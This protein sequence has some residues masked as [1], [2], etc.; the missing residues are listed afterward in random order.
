M[1]KQCLFLIILSTVLFQTMLAQ[2]ATGSTVKDPY[3]SLLGQ[4]QVKCFPSQKFLVYTDNQHLILEIVG[5]GRGELEK[6]S[7]NKF[8]LKGLKPAAYVEFKK[9]LND[10]AISLTWIQNSPIQNWTKDANDNNQVKTGIAA[11]V[12][13]YSIKSSAYQKMIMENRNNHLICTLI[14]PNREPFEIKPNGP[15]SFVFGSDGY[16]CEYAFAAD[17]NG[18]FNKLT[19][20]QSGPLLCPRIAMIAENPSAKHSFYKRPGFTRGDTL[21]GMLSPLRSCYDVL[22]YKL[23]VTVEPETKSLRGSNT[24]RFKTI[25][26]FNKIQVDLYNNMKIEKI[27]YHN[28]ALQYTREA[29]AVFIELPGQ[30]PTG[31]IDEITIYYNGVPQL[32]DLVKGTSGFL[33]EQDKTGKKWIESVSQGSGASTWWPCK[34]HLTDKPDSM[35]VSITVPSGLSEVSNGKFLGKTALPNGQT[36][37]DWY[38]SYPIN[39]YDVVL[40]IGDYIHFTGKH[41]NGKDSLLLNYYCLSSNE[42]LA[43][44]FYTRVD[45]LLTVFE[46]AF[47]PYPF[48]Q[49]GFAMVESPY[50]MEHQ[51]AVSMGPLL[52]PTKGYQYDSSILINTFWHETAHEWWGNNV[53]CRD[54]ADFWIHESFA[55]YSEILAREKLWGTAAANKYISEQRGENKETIIGYPDV[56]DFHMGDMYP[57]GGRMLVTLKSIINNDSLWFAILKGIQE[58]F[59]YQSV[60]TDDIVQ[61]FNTATQTDYSYLFEQYLR[62][63]ALPL[64]IMQIKKEGDGLELQYKWQANI[65]NFRMPVKVTLTKNEYGFIYPTTEWKTIRLSGINK[66]DFH[67]DTTGFYYDIKTD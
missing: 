56:N 9:D 52:E 46:N 66:K 25:A 42:A 29:D 44:N 62:H 21:L 24:I 23:D 19:V 55:T 12:G 59:R 53:T 41:Y 54:Y 8:K 47:G 22:F 10:S 51:S 1:H 32:L 37:Y 33:W 26:D 20:T 27:L 18:M 31:T 11:Y 45:P 60:S 64:L 30:I 13:K 65:A 61:Y 4:Y 40:Y 57:K 36:R 67:A 16:T 38:I 48:K 34:D 3:A 49:D 35:S 39:T 28:K 58:K 15:N 14:N 17:E 6:L 2:P 50:C 63:P 43:R 5:Q 7:D